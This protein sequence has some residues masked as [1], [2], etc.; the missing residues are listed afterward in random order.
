MGRCQQ[1]SII[2]GNKVILRLMLSK[3]V[4][5]KKWAP[6][7]IFFNEKKIEKDL[8]DF[9]HRKLTLKVKLWHFLTQL[10]QFLKFN[11]FLWV[12]WFSGKS[13]SN[14]VPPIWKLHNLYCHNCRP[15]RQNIVSSSFFNKEQQVI[16]SH[17]QSSPIN[18]YSLLTTWKYN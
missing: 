16:P 6:E 9:C 3:N 10:T 4:N 1:L 7:L 15:T 2:L 5:N 13:L 18:F 12:C 11:N 8:D 14:F 17:T